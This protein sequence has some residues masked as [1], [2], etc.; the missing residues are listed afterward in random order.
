MILN[1][2]NKNISLPLC[3]LMTTQLWNFTEPSCQLLCFKYSFLPLILQNRNQ[4]LLPKILLIF[5]IIS[6]F[7]GT[8]AIT[9]ILFYSQR[10]VRHQFYRLS[11]FGIFLC[12]ALRKA[13]ALTHLFLRFVYFVRWFGFK[14]SADVNFSHFCYL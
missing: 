7:T 2:S 4:G 14:I 12:T 10:L 13:G 1:S 5:Q 6:D 3:T 9:Q 11:G 8:L